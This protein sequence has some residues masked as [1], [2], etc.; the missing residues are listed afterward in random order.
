MKLK[1]V[2]ILDPGGNITA[3]IRS[4]VKVGDRSA[5]SRRLLLAYNREKPQNRWIEQVAFEEIFSG[6]RRLRMEGGEFSGNAFRCYAFLRLKETVENKGLF[7]VV[8]ESELL[9]ARIVGNL[10][11]CQMPV[12]KSA[13]LL[14]KF[15]GLPYVR[16]ND[17]SYL[18]IEKWYDKDQRWQY[19]KGV[20]Y[21]KER[22]L[23]KKE[24]V[25]VLYLKKIGVSYKMSPYVYFNKG[26]RW[27]LYK[28]TSC[29][30]GS[31]AVGVF[32]YWKMN[33]EIKDLRVIQPSG[34]SIGVSVKKVSTGLEIW[35]RGKV[36]MICNKNFQL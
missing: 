20:Q 27:D 29:G 19:Q 23:L 30:S 11:S 31:T 15:K 2:S 24:A 12:A 25:G 28:E 26:G 33:K 8:D 14:I 6:K 22:N 9:K 10:V 13:R 18:L 34:R 17:I 4:G 21:L 1:K 16:L 35:I 3:I 7:D 32:T 5:V 36:E